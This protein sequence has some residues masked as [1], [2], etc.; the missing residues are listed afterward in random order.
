M[1]EPGEASG[2]NSGDGE[3]SGAARPERVDP[4]FR[5]G[6]YAT[7]DL[8]GVGGVIR[9]R[10]EDFLVDEIP[11]Y[12]PCGEGEHIYMLVQKTGL[13]TH[14][15]VGI[16]AHHFGVTRGAIGF[17][18]LKDKQAI[19]RQVVSVHVP[20]KK[21]EDFPM[22][23]HE[24]IAVLWADYHTNKL[25]RG[26]LAGNR[27]SIRIR[28]VRIQDVLTARKV[29][30]R[31]EAG[32]VPN[33]FGEQRFGM[34]GANHLIGRDLVVG[35][36]EGV[37]AKLLGPTERKPELNPEA[38]AQFVEGKF[39]EAM[40][41]M[42][43]SA[44]AERAA[45]RALAQG[46]SAKRAVLAV[47]PMALGFFVSAFQSAV[48]NR[49]L[50]ERMG[51]GSLA[52]LRAGDV[53][54]KHENGAVFPVSAAI[55]DDPATAE[56]LRKIEISP[57]GPMW[58]ATMVRTSGETGETEV[59]A[60]TGLGVGMEQ[61]E[62]FCRRASPLIEAS[63]RALRIP[64]VA[65]DVEAGSDEHGA[66]IRVAFE[67]PRGSFATAVLPEIMKVKP[68]DAESEDDED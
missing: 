62:L 63:R 58:H 18:G 32:G 47:D 51:E 39:A 15:L 17:A 38:R 57:S 25:R 13:S 30:Q 41:S 33:R 53:A 43:R 23:R 29:L 37:I 60:L 19:T 3:R 68:E 26:H 55:A 45:L 34:T 52:I 48:F 35:D 44:R 12:E 20:G 11:A 54:F 64:L 16:L 61:L 14:D 59:A 21:I 50:E 31:L 22:L 65:P 2:A 36:F 6:R 66:Y 46:K 10:P 8:P 67:L 9:Q 27:F 42:P 5:G 28:G 7:A 56:R 1:S 49:V 24:K 40:E 4:L